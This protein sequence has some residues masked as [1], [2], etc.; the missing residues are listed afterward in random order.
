MSKKWVTFFSR[1]GAEI[2]EVSTRLGR[3]P[4]LIV[5]N[6]NM[7]E[8]SP[9][10]AFVDFQKRFGIQ[11]LRLS[12]KPSIEEYQFMID[13][14]SYIFA[15]CIITLHGYLRIIPEF[16][17]NRFYILNS[18]PGDIVN[19]PFLKGFNPQEKAFKNNLVSSGVV[20]HEVVPEVDSGKI[21]SLRTARLSG[22][23]LDEVYEK[24]HDISIAQWCDVLKDYLGEEHA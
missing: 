1:T 14:Y 6:K 8:D 2:V 9:C 19:Y 7:E 4:D 21:I 16:L 10:E 23:T 15:D 17:C 5:T 22:L 18:H 24:L 13:H 12:T 11:M 3:I 20:V